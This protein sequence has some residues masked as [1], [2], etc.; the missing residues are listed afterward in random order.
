M[1][2]VDFQERPYICGM[3]GDTFARSDHLRRHMLTH[4]R[5]HMSSRSGLASTPATAPAPVVIKGQSTLLQGVTGNQLLVAQTGQPHTVRILPPL[6]GGPHQ[7]HTVQMPGGQHIQLANI[8]SLPGVGL[9]VT[10]EVKQGAPLPEGVMA[11]EAQGQAVSGIPYQGSEDDPN[12]QVIEVNP[13]QF[14]LQNIT[15][16]DE[17]GMEKQTQVLILQCDNPKDVDLAALESVPNVFLSEEEAN[18]LVKA[19]EI[20]ITETAAGE[21]QQQVVEN[22]EARVEVPAPIA[23][24]EAST[25]KPSSR[26]KFRRS[27]AID[28]SSYEET[29]GSIVLQGGGDV[30]EQTAVSS[31]DRP[32]VTTASVAANT[33]HSRKRGRTD[34]VED[35]YASKYRVLDSQGG[36]C[37]L[38]PMFAPD[39]EDAS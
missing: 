12:V 31:I 15:E 39:A 18:R 25:S 26:R 34:S 7:P 35:D 20:V 21:G 23:V 10:S 27:E 29:M 9:G 24:I 14:Q 6:S 2:C 13:E 37:A 3:C 8:D 33:P 17:N 32:E 19:G 16:T 28:V 1:L 11:V 36:Q 4:E 22:Y 38:E 5:G 30:F